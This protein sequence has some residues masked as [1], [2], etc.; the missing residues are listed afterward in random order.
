VKSDGVLIL[1]ELAGAASEIGE[2]LIINPMD[3]DEL[4]ESINE[5]LRMSLEEQNQRMK[6]MQQR[7]ID[8]DVTH[9]VD[10]F[11]FQLDDIKEE[12]EYEMGK[13]LSDT[14]TKKIISAYKEA[15]NRYIFLDY[16]GTVVPLVSHPSKAKPEDET[17]R[18]LQ[19]ISSCEKTTLTIISGRESK[20]LN[21]WVGDLP[22]NIVAEHG[23]AIR[24]I[25]EPWVY[26]ENHSESW[27]KF[28]RPTLELFSKRCP[29]SFVEEKNLTLAW[30]YR[31]VE[32]DI[33]FLR[34]RELL[35][36][37]YHLIRNANLHIID[38]NKVIEVRIAG[39]DK[40]AASKKIIAGKNV[41]FILAIGDDRTDE[42]MFR[43]LA[44]KAIT[45]KVGAGLI[46]NSFV[47]SITCFGLA[48]LRPDHRRSSSCPSHLPATWSV[49]RGADTLLIALL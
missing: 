29:G 41:D 22:I 16:D 47:S 30:H 6:L 36:N 3:E 34:S 27:K 8:Y 5:A 2:A 18:L 17:L 15:S 37:L 7:L 11:L 42:D 31:N 39:I 38:G 33:G 10:D 45:I 44:D 43:A 32:S 28:I 14:S 9:W 21:E 48:P 1:S 20:T 40:G 24:N 49:C 12:Q 46:L 19:D 35:D 26:E 4:S 25:G 13:F 23:A